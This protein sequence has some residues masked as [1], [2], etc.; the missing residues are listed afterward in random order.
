VQSSCIFLYFECAIEVVNKATWHPCFVLAIEAFYRRLASC[1]V[2]A[3]GNILRNSENDFWGSFSFD[4]LRYLVTKRI[5]R[6][7][8]LLFTFV[9]G[10][11]NFLGESDNYSCTL[12][13]VC[14]VHSYTEKGHV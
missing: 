10:F 12:C 1:S 3:F 2:S 8:Y 14:V 7:L 13:R 5:S 9:I 11:V 6:Q 4:N